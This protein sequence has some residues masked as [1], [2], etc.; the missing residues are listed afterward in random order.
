M[1][2]WI[3]T[4][5]LLTLTATGS[6]VPRQ[7]PDGAAV[8]SRSCTSCHDV[9]RIETSA[10]DRD[11]WIQTLNRMREHGAEV[12]LIDQ[13]ALIDYL[14]N[15]HGPIPEG[16]GGELLLER[17][18]ICH[19]LGR[20]REHDGT[21]EL[22]ED[23]VRAMLNEGATLSDRELAI[24]IDYLTEHFGPEEAGEPIDR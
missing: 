13:I 3:A 16:E 7:S 21:R 8:V 6:P 5:A 18:T 10:L 24:L 22:W 9:R 19:D 12:G 15:N 4:A 20:I 23:A 11:G 2:A 1:L 14:V 17:C